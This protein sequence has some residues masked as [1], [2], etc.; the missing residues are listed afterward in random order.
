MKPVRTTTKQAVGFSAVGNAHVQKIPGGKINEGNSLD[1]AV[2]AA[3]IYNS[4]SRM[5]EGLGKA[6]QTAREI[7]KGKQSYGTAKGE[8]GS[9]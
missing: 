8:D 3:S 7:K 4:L 6:F 1:V 9:C 5:S 2:Y